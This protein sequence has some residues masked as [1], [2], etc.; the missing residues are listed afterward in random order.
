MLMAEQYVIVIK[1]DVDKRNYVDFLKK[2]KGRSDKSSN[3]GYE[4][5]MNT[6]NVMMIDDNPNGLKKNIGSNQNPYAN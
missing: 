3:I 4:E 2:R 5:L 1:D 6:N